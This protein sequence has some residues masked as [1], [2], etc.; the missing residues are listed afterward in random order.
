[1]QL[2]LL[3]MFL[4][5]FIGNT[6]S[7]FSVTLESM[8]IPHNITEFFMLGLSQNSEVQRVLFVVFLLIYVV[9]VCGNMLI[10]VTITSSPTLAS[11]VYFFLANLSFI[12]TFY[13]FSMAP[14]LI[15]DSL[16]EGRTISYEG[17]MAEL[18]GAHFLGGV[19][20]ILLTLM[21]YDHYVA[22]FKPLHCTTIMTR[23]L[24]AMLVGVAWL[25]GFLHSL[26]QLLLV[27][28]LP[29]CGPN[30]INH[31]ACDLYP[32]L[33]VGCTNMH[34]VGLLVV[35]NS[36][37]ICLLNFLMLAA[38]YIVILYS[39]RS[40]SAD[41]R[42][43]ALSTCGAHFIVFALFFV[44]CIFT[45]ML[46]FSIL[47]IDKNMAL[48]YGILTPMLNPLIYTLRNEEVK[49]AMRKIFTW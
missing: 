49:N 36:G 23:H 27:L 44:P 16:Y 32:L 11:P 45:Y 8:E 12:D 41:G 17:C 24:C 31:F 13:S 43:K 38:S 1:R 22:I 47:S 29:F 34:V 5:V 6:A 18:F 25:G 20:I 2:V 15:A 33:G 10:V 14:K 40:H 39:L 4:F 30:V 46:P 28:W 21:A 35:A 48:F 42:R 7:E 26:V 3:L 37:L 19:E 9:T